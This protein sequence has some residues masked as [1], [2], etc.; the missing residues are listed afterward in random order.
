MA[1]CHSPEAGE[2]RRLDEEVFELVLP[3]AGRVGWLQLLVRRLNQD[4]G[5]D[6]ILYPALLQEEDDEEEQEER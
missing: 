1:E 6:G 3:E 5:T 2:G 4:T